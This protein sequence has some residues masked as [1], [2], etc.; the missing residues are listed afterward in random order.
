VARPRSG[1]A[2]GATAAERALFA[3]AM[4]GTAPYDGRRGPAPSAAPPS[5]S[6]E[7]PQRSPTAAPPT[8]SGRGLDKRTAQKL[9]RGAL[10]LEGRLDLHGHTLA[11]AS[12]AL[13][14]FVFAAHAGGRRCV[15]VITG[16][17]MPRADAEAPFREDGRRGV[18]RELVPRWLAEPPLMDC[19][20][21]TAPAQPRDGGAGALYVLLRRRR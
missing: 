11:A 12:G 4:R 6:P 16:R 2:R 18:L 21:A 1:K 14:A 5:V 19:V 7:P 10:A 17:G 9:R 3:A 13:R 8:R 20:L 15:L